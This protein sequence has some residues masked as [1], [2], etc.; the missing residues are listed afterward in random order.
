M[1]IIAGTSI[2]VAA[3]KMVEAVRNGAGDIVIANF[4]GCDI[5]ARKTTTPEMI[6]AYFNSHRAAVSAQYEA[7]RMET[8]RR[9]EL[10]P[11]ML[12]MLKRYT[13]VGKVNSFTM[14]RALTQLI[15]RCENPKAETDNAQTENF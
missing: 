7:E 2:D 4:N 1:D 3:V 12:A 14:N 9:A 13:G 15:E 11:D 5:E 10:Y 8:L 6:T